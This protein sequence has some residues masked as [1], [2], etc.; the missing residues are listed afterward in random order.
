MINGKIKGIVGRYDRS[1]VAV[2]V[3]VGCMITAYIK[4]GD[5]VD[6]LIKRSPVIAELQISGRD[7]KKDSETM[8]E[9][10]KEI[11]QDIRGILREIRKR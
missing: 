7:Q 1:V 5:I 8:M 10:I 2:I 9:N 6:N 3:T 4:M 11:K